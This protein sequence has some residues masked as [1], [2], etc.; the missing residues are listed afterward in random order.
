MNLQ[1]YISEL[2]EKEFR[3]NFLRVDCFDY[4]NDSFDL[5]GEVV[6]QHEEESDLVV[7]KLVRIH[8]TADSQGVLVAL[9]WTVA[10]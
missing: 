4:Y 10:D 6:I 1:E 3:D 7:D 8:D 9:N 2:A 5:I